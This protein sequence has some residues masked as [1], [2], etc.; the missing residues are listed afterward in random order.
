MKHLADTQAEPDESRVEDSQLDLADSQAEP[1][2]SRAEVEEKKPDS[3]QL[4]E[5]KLEQHV[6]ELIEQ[7][8]ERNEYFRRAAERVANKAKTDVDIDT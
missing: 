5:K 2:E 6:A 1:D 8:V 4:E 7:L 3:S